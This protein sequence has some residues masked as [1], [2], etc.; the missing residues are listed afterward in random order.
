M[1]NRRQFVTATVWL[2][3]V[4]GLGTVEVHGEDATFVMSGV[5]SSPPTVTPTSLGAETAKCDSSSTAL[6]VLHV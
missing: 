6:Y 5:S 4:G 3:V 1:A 2:T